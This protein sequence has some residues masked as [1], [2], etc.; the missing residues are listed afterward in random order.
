MSGVTGTEGAS[1]QAR[2]PSERGNPRGAGANA[3]RFREEVKPVEVPPSRI[4]GSAGNTGGGALV[5]LSGGA[6]G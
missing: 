6:R 5:T 2:N 3:S 4:T 1:S